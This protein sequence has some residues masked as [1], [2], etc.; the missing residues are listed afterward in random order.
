MRIDSGTPLYP[1]LHEPAPASGRSARF[2]P[3]QTPLRLFIQP[4]ITHPYVRASPKNKPRTNPGPRLPRLPLQ[5][6]LQNRRLDTYSPGTRLSPG[7][8]T[9]PTQRPDDPHIAKIHKRSLDK[10]QII[11]Q[12]TSG[13]GTWQD[14]NRD[15]KTDISYSF[16]NRGFNEAQKQQARKSIQS[17][18]DVANLAFTENGGS[19]EG[20]LTFKIANHLRTAE[21][22]YPNGFNGGQTFYN[23]NF[24]TRTVMTH[25]IGH[26]LGLTHPGKYDGSAD[27][28][29]RVYSQDS[30]AHT[31]MS[32]FGAQ[33][34]G[35]LIRGN[36]I[37][38]MMDDISAIQ[39]KYG[40]NHQ[41]RRGDDT[42]GFNA[43]AGR[44]Y[45]S[46]KS[47]RDAA[48]FCIWD[49]AGNDTLDAS[50]Y[51]QDQVLNL[52]AGSF[53]DVGGYR[54][55]VSIARNCL[56]ENAVGGTGNDV[57]IGNEADNRLTGGGGGDRMRGGGGADTF[58]YNH[59]SD[60]TPGNPDEIMDFTSGTD[61]IDL[62]QALRNAGLSSLSFVNA[63]SG[64]AG[65]AILTYD[66]KTGTGTV[67]IDSTGDGKANLLIKTQGRVRPEDIIPFRNAQ[68]ATTPTRITPRVDTT[69]A[70]PRFTFNTASESG[71][72]NS[73][74]LTDFI[75]GTD[76]IDLR[77]VQAEAKTRFTL[78]QAF[79]G[80]I[81]DT[82]IRFNPQT[83]RYFIAVDLTGNRQTDFLVRSSQLIRPGDVIAG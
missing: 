33:S 21:G 58:V 60:S 61:K 65:E 26:A 42:Y 49:G 34:S 72:T 28:W 48:N 52:R 59:V 19:A 57:L 79:T 25:E 36:P 13:A 23:Q 41:V 54:G 1:L 24:A 71:M 64:K 3:F 27:E 22:Y 82:V 69:E 77:G 5:P 17:W 9:D 66:D 29:Q 37:A 53:S 12:L 7:G 31:V 10:Q 15:N 70:T 32:Y 2:S 76:K 67:S 51:H 75:S 63:W 18:G 4:F 6:R 47:N 11:E 20:R 39:K 74:L 78:V 46:L 8:N 43:T 83:Q 40:A 14:R 62:S 45:Y 30:K 81:G 55:N 50:G 68:P 56:I 80:R 16:N 38:P 44:D 35:K 73:R